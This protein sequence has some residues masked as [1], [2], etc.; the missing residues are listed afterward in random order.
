M[1]KNSASRG[2]QSNM[3][4]NQ[5][6]GNSARVKGKATNPSGMSI[7]TGRGDERRHGTSNT[8]MHT[9][10]GN[11]GFSSGQISPQTH[12]KANQR[13]GASGREERGSGAIGRAYRVNEEGP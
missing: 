2:N 13:M 3:Q 4:D 1:N 7:P 5:Q 9:H 11:T 6:L 10:A 12:D 8:G